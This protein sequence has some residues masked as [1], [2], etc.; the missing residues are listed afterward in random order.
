MDSKDNCA[1]LQWTHPTLTADERSNHKDRCTN[2]DI[3]IAN[4][5]IQWSSRGM[6]GLA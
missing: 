4:E 5:C 1:S 6:S 2:N 3:C